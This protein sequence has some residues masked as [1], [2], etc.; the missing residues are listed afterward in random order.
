M[1]TEENEAGPVLDHAVI[2]GL[3]ELGGT[4]DP[5]LLL[6]LVGLFL[7]EAP[8]YVDEIVAGFEGS[9]LERVRR[10]SHA[11]KSSSANMGASSL[12]TLARSIE[13]SAK[14]S[15]LD[16]LREQSSALGGVYR[17]TVEELKALES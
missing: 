17:R 14:A 4:D 10:A 1:N 2:A 15:D 7:Q 13:S 16:L 12:S 3:R 6:E 8:G 11:L 5:G 9:D